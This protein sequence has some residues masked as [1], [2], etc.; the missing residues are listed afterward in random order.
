MP[1]G[2]QGRRR[3]LRRRRRLPAADDRGRADARR[4][5][6]RRGGRA[7][8]RRA[9]CPTARSFGLL[10]Q[11]PGA[12][13]ALRDHEAADRRRCTSAARSSPSRPT[14]SPLVLLPPARAR[15]APTSSVGSSQRFGVPLGYGGPHAAFM[16]VRAGLERQ[17]PGPPR[18]RL[19]R[20]RRAPRAAA[21]AA[22]PRA[23]HPAREGDAQHLHRAGAAG[24]DGVDVRGLPR[25]RGPRGD[26]D[27]RAPLRLD[28]RRGAP[29]AAGSSSRHEA[30]F[31]TIQVRVPRH[32]DAV[33]AAARQSGI[34][35]RLVDADTV[36]IS[37]TR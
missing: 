36:G 27:A 29:R 8:S 17:L 35:L 32:A 34:N 37:S 19:G 15:S 4:A 25:A 10:L 6:R 7:R 24:G 13:G 16:C 20:R 30:F 23:A 11:Y 18:R 22:D 26:R 5:A 9:A 33:V 28:P 12:S 3:V 2:R 21:R 1:A 31:D 14:C